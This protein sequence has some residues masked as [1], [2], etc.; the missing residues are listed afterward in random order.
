MKELIQEFNHK[1]FTAQLRKISEIQEWKEK[2]ITITRIENVS[3][4]ISKR[5]KEFQVIV[6]GAFPEDEQSDWEVV[7]DGLQYVLTSKDFVSNSLSII[8]LQG[9][10]RTATYQV[11]EIATQGFDRSKEARFRCFVPVEPG[12]LKSFAYVV[13]TILY[14]TDETRY[15][16]DCLRLDVDGVGL[17]VVQYKDKAS[18]DEFYIFDALAPQSFEDFQET[19]FAARQALGFISGFMPGGEELVFDG[20]EFLYSSRIRPSL[21]MIHNPVNRNPYAKL[22]DRK[23]IAETYMNKLSVI[24]MGVASKLATQIKQNEV[25][26]AAMLL[27]IEAEHARSLL[28]IPSILAVIVESMAKQLAVGKT[29]KQV[30]ISDKDLAKSIKEDLFAVIDNHPEVDFD[31]SVKLKRRLQE[32][33]KPVVYEKLTNN[34]KLTEPFFQLGIQ[35]SLNDINAIE[36]RNDLLHGNLLIENEERVTDDQINTYMG[37]IAAKLYTLISKLILKN[38]GYDGYV[39]N[40]ARFYEEFAGEEEYYNLI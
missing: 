20:E 2:P 36:H 28:I 25:F 35:L 5:P 9:V 34:E 31:T 11:R 19:C 39:I 38:A 21:K 13:E 22:Y 3:A 26:S 27:L 29:G 37:Y 33:N 15:R 7:I 30:P 10:S 4:N 12:E 32:F 8:A 18:G 6:G 16:F 24:P 23:D 40:H 1:S 14:E 17:D